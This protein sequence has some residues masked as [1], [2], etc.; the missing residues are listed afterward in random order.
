MN[1]L[2]L[3]RRRVPLAAPVA[4]QP[5]AAPEVRLLPAPVAAPPGDGGLHVAARRLSEEE[6]ARRPRPTFTPA[7]DPL[8]ATAQQEALAAPRHEKFTSARQDRELLG[9]VLD[10][11]R[12]IDTGG[13]ARQFAADF[14]GLPLF[15]DVA[16]SLGWCGLHQEQPPVGR[17]R[18]TF[19]TW[20]RR[21]MDAIDRQAWQA[22]S[23]ADQQIGRTQAEIRMELDGYQRAAARRVTVSG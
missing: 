23:D 4:V 7:V 19:A 12:G 5:A 14:R 6:A 20:Q 15:H 10:G 9:R 22:R 3:R 13:R 1:M 21:A 8:R 16:R 18:Y 11:L 2:Q 17:G